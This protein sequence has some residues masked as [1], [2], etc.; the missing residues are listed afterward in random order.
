MAFAGCPST[1]ARSLDVDERS[2]APSSGQGAPSRLSH[3]PVQIKLVPAS[4]PYL[5]G[6]RLLVAADCTAFSYG[7]FHEDYIKGRVC[8]VGC[9]KLDGVDYTEKLLALIAEN[10]VE[11]ILVARMEVPCCGGLER[12]VSQAVASCGKPIPVRID[13]ISAEGR[14][15]ES[16]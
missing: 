5:K 13:V 1:Q 11:D 15:V 4:A 16:R 8:L 14:V 6:A 2:Q 9:P 3:W 12:A 7:A 10:D